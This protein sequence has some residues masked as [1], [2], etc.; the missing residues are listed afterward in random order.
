MND[1]AIVAAVALVAAAAVAV[2][3]LRQRAATLIRMEQ[4]DERERGLGP[5]MEACEKAVDKMRGEQNTFMVNAR[6]R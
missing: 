2:V 6:N 5:R 1:V 3:W 4:R